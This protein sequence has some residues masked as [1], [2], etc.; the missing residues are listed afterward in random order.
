MAGEDATDDR[1]EGD[2]MGEETTDA[3]L[4]E[5]RGV[6]SDARGSPVA[7]LASRL[8]TGQKVLQDV[9][10]A[11]THKA[12]NSAQKDYQVTPPV[13]D[14]QVNLIHLGRLYSIMNKNAVERRQM[15]YCDDMAVSAA[16]LQQYNL[17]GISHMNEM[18]N[19]PLRQK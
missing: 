9:S 11:S 1:A 13:M 2:R 6:L 12:W 15:T 5:R 17:Q 10:H 19:C 16:F 14:D 4:D 3:E 8:H 18:C 7:V